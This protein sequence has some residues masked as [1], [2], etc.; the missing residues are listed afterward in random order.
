MTRLAL[1]LL[2]AAVC[3]ADGPEPPCGGAVFPTYSDVDEA[4]AVKVWEHNELGREWTPPACTGWKEPGF[5]TL[6]AVAGRFHYAG[7]R[8]GLL[9]RIGA[10]SELKG[11]HYWS[12]THQQWRTLII[13]AYA[14]SAVSG[15]QRRPDLT[16]EELTEGSS[17]Y[18]EQEDSLTG[19]ATYEMQ[20]AVATPERLVFDTRNLTTMRYFMVPVFHPGDV[21]SVYFLERETKDVWRYYNLARLGENTS[22]LATGHAPSSINRAVAFYR[23]LVGIPTDQEPPAAR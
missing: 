16:P 10:I 20:I 13:S 2:A 15:G 6:V 18:F 8:E 5:S 3:R 4:P 21:E 19:K 14:L 11:M 7:G 9:R 17:V 12:T 1:A 22:S 23:H